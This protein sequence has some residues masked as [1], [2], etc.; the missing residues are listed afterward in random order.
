[1]VA[2]GCPKRQFWAI[3]S[4]PSPANRSNAHARLQQGSLRVLFSN[5]QRVLLAF[6]L[7]SDDHSSSSQQHLD[8]LVNVYQSR[9]EQPKLPGTA[10]KRNT[11]RPQRN[12]DSLFPKYVALSPSLRPPDL[13][14]DQLYMSTDFRRAQ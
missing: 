5:P 8:A 11:S 1:M 9:A 7:P 4:H 10:R 13:F 6:F 2:S 12:R 14:T 3:K